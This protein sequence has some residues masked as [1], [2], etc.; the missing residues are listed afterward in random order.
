MNMSELQK[1]LYKLDLREYFS[2]KAF[3]EFEITQSPVLEM[4]G[5]LYSVV[6]Q[7]IIRSSPFFVHYSVFDEE[8]NQANTRIAEKVYHYVAM[9][10]MVSFMAEKRSQ[11]LKADNRKRK[12][13]DIEQVDHFISEKLRLKYLS[14]HGVNIIDLEAENTQLVEL[15]KILESTNLL[16]SEIDYWT[17]DDLQTFQQAWESFW[18][19]YQKRLYHLL[20]FYSYC[21]NIGSLEEALAG[22]KLEYIYLEAKVMYELFTKSIPE[23]APFIENVDD[24]IMLMAQ[25]GHVMDKVNEGELFKQATAFLSRSLHKLS[26]VLLRIALP[27]IVMLFVLDVVSFSSITSVLLNTLGSFIAYSL[28]SNG[29]K[30]SVENHLV[31][32]RVQSI[33]EQPI[34]Q[35]E[36]HQ[37]YSKL[38]Q[39][40][41]NES[42]KE[43]I[44]E[45]PAVRVRLPYLFMIIGSFIILFGFIPD[46]EEFMSTYISI[47]GFVFL[48]G[49][50]LRI[51]LRG[52]V[53]LSKDGLKFK[54]L[55]LNTIS[56]NN[57]RVSPSGRI[58]KIMLSFALQNRAI[59]FKVPKG[60]RQDAKS[61]LE[62][63]C[64][65]NSVSNQNNEKTLSQ[66]TYFVLFYGLLFVILILVGAFL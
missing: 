57:V 5:K 24:F 63:W 42:K 16:L 25:L 28:V 33:S 32:Q 37:A 18:G 34:V 2:R 49:I 21:N 39:T 58:I 29:L 41:D 66:L 3:P 7:H 15:F 51:I 12:S 14:I 8:G 50:L 9:S 35:L 26:Q 60:Y 43:Q 46:I 44:Y 22:T 17:E 45:F 27:I 6:G 36:Y 20:Q 40:K 4:E 13:R 54:W 65:E 48:I 55:K 47:G 56:I 1:D 23:E 61:T 64:I 38:Q 31:E 52:Q 19:V 53:Y 10:H 59:V 30:K 62:K 11:I